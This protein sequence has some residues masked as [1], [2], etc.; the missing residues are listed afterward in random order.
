MPLKLA[1]GRTC[2]SRR[3]PLGRY[4]FPDSSAAVAFVLGGELAV[5]GGECA[6]DASSG[7]C[8]IGDVNGP[9][10]AQGGVATGGGASFPIDFTFLRYASAVRSIDRQSL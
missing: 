7:F 2:T 1:E 3:S 10:S 6:P 4:F 8:A 5:P 9:G